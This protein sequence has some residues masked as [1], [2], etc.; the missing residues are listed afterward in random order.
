[1]GSSIHAWHIERIKVTY[2]GSIQVCGIQVV[3]RYHPG[4]ILTTYVH[5]C[6]T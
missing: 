2:M 3:L 4:R 5:T 1:M 6:N